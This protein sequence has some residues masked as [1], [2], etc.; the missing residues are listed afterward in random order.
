MNSLMHGYAP[1]EQGTI[2][3]D[4]ALDGESVKVKYYD[5]GVGITQE[6][7]DHIFDPFY[8]TKRGEGG[9]GLGLNL[10]HNIVLK[11]LNGSIS[12]KSEPGQGAEFTIVFPIH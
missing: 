1:D 10:V 8:T 7:I 5:D 3:I 4:L 12:C 2:G 11:K 9:T 6:H